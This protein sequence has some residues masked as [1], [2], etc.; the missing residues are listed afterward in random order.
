MKKIDF[1][2]RTSR[3]DKRRKNYYLDSVMGDFS[4]ALDEVGVDN[5]MGDYNNLLSEFIEVNSL[6]GEFRAFLKN[7]FSKLDED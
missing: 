3:Q 7:H 5:S 1:E 4:L 2:N 6:R